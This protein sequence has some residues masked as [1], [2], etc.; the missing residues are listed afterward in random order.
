M[1]GPT[2][3]SHPP[4]DA[5]SARYPGNGRSPAH[6][7]RGRTRSRRRPTLRYGA[8]LVGVLVAAVCL[9]I[10][11]SLIGAATTPGNQGFNAK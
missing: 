7:G 8:R 3:A 10:G 1:S 5:R 6:R 2:R 4:V 11:A 9:F